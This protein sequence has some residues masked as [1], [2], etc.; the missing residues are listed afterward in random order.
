MAGARS[1]A[2]ADAQPDSAAAAPAPAALSI[3]V[4]RIDALGIEPEIVDRLE[5]LFRME[6]ERYAGRALPSRR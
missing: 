4:W 3:A 5:T 6:L 1:D 2:R